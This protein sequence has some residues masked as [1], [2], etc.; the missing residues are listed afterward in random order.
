MIDPGRRT[1]RQGQGQGRWVVKNSLGETIAAK[2]LFLQM[3]AMAKL[4]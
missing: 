4:F 2:G 1:P 3:T